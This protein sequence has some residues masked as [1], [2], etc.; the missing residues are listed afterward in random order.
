MNR[1]GILVSKGKQFEHQVVSDFLSGKVSRLQASELLGVQQR[2]ISRMARRIEKKGLMSL[3][4]GNVGRSP[5]NVVSKSTQTEVMRLVEGRYFDFNMTHCLEKLTQE[6]GYKISYMTLRRWCHAKHLVKRKKRRPSKARRHRDRMDCEGLLLQMDGSPHK[7]NG[8]DIWTLIGAIDDATSKIPYAEFFLSEDTLSCM[9]VM[10]KII[11]RNG[12]PYALYVDKAGWFGGSKRQNFAQ[13][14]RACEELDINVIFANSP[15]AKGRIE[16]AWN[17]IQDRL[18]PEMRIRNIKRVPAAN[19]YLLSQFLPNYWD[20]RNTV[21]A[22]NSEAKYRQVS[23]GTDLK[24]IFCIK[25]YRV[26]KGDH[27]I[28]WNSELYQLDPQ[29]NHSIQGQEI[30]IRTYLDLTWRTFFAGREILIAKINVP[31][32]YQAAA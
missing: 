27:T 29:M 16:R 11:E 14:K 20:R 19:D 25:E 4:H 5:S 7:W 15:Q 18:I 2:S 32:R 10:K 13:F 26:V 17:T 6:H 28:S 12:I 22:R 23:P 3:V 21:T 9:A 31:K 8:R 30:E 1:E 24:E